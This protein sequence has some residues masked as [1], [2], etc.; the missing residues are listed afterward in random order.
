MRGE[1]GRYHVDFVLKI[2]EC[3][4]EGNSILLLGVKARSKGNLGVRKRVCVEKNEGRRG[5]ERGGQTCPMES[6]VNRKKI[7]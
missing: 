5:D 3:L 4:S 6:K 2:I 1:E 7:F